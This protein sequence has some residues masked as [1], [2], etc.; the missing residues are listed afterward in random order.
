[1]TDQRYPWDEPSTGQSWR[2]WVTGHLLHHPDHR[3]RF[4]AGHDFVLVPTIDVAR[5]HERLHDGLLSLMHEHD[6]PWRVPEKEE[7]VK[8]DLKVTVT[9]AGNADPDAVLAKMR[10]D[11]LW[12]TASPYKL[13]VTKVERADGQELG[14]DSAFEEWWQESH[15]EDDA[16]TAEEKDW[17]REGMLFGMKY[18][19]RNK[20]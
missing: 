1:M 10:K 12:L 14:V 18:R 8:L 4:P 16:G 9:Q 19:Q 6:R 20:S 2:S 7:S 17:A 13:P 3:S 5:K 11:D 15:C